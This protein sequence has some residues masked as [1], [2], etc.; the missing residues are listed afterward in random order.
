LIRAQK[1]QSKTISCNGQF[2]RATSAANSL[3]R[4]GSWCIYIYIH[5]RDTHMYACVHIRN[6]KYAYLALTQSLCTRHKCGELLS[7]TRQLV[8]LHIHTH[9]CMR[10][11]TC[12]YKCICPLP[13][14]LARA[15]SAANSL[16]RDGSWLQSLARQIASAIRRR[17]LMCVCVC[18]SKI[19][20]PRP[21]RA[22]PAR[23]TP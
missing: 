9:I 14:P 2:A 16:V 22:P 5:T 19:T 21:S 20:Y 3:V 7:A 6:Y 15:T 1:P 8:A 23:R 13:T 12:K 10:V 18:T 11:G 17:Q 4:D